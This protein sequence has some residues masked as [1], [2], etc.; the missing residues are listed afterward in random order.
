M[1]RSTPGLPV[2]HQLPEFTQTHVHWVGDAI[3][4]SH[5]LSS[6][7][8]PTFNLSQHQ[9]LFKWA[10]SSHQVAEV[11]EWTAISFS[12][13]SSQSRNRTQV[14]CIARRFLTDW[15]M[16]E[17]LKFYHLKRPK[18]YW[19]KFHF[20][21]AKAHPT[22]LKNWEIPNRI[23]RR[24]HSLVSTSTTMWVR[25]LVT[26]SCPTLC[27]LMDSSPLGSS[28]HGVLQAR[29]LEWVAISFSRGSSQPR[30]WTQVFRIAG[31]VFTIQATK[32]ALPL[33]D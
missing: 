4:P 28:V 8:P 18:I 2:H 1:N 3:Q 32:E 9:G 7:S 23:Q 14:S 15:A 5:P 29:I 10:S 20:I 16:R 30:E 21:L 22:D 25:M 19:S 13:G 17:A 11:L 31:R 33:W 26:Q 24:V 6:P 27:D 12:R